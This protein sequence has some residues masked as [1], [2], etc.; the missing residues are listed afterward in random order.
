MA[1]TRKK[2]SAPRTAVA[3]SVISKARKGL[4]APSWA[5]CAE[6]KGDVYHKHVREARRF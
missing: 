5:G 2:K 3:K 1:V 4:L 6:W